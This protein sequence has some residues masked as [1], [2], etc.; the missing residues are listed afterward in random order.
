MAD[1]EKLQ[2]V[3][4]LVAER[5]F[6]IYEECPHCHGS[7]IGPNETG[8]LIHCLSARALGADWELDGVLSLI[9]TATEVSWVNGFMDHDLYIVDPEGKGWLFQVKR[10]GRLVD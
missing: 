10:P 7:G 2:E 8:R 5:A 1:Q 6:P 9:D 3:R 4:R